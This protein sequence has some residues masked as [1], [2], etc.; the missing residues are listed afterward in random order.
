M[1]YLYTGDTKINTGTKT[2]I[3]DVLIWSSNLVV[4]MV[5]LECVC[6][7]LSKYRVSFRLDKCRFLLNRVE[8]VGHDLTPVGNCPAKSKFNMIKD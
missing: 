6:K 5:Y 7:V 3:D 8:Y 1:I 2:I 4:I